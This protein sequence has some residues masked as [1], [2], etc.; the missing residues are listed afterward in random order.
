MVEIP[1]KLPIKDRRVKIAFK[2]F[3]T[4]DFKMAAV[5]AKSG[6]F[7]VFVESDNEKSG[8]RVEKSGVI[9][10]FDERDVEKNDVRDEFRTEYREVNNAN[11][12]TNIG[13]TNS[14]DYLCEFYDHNLSTNDDINNETYTD[15]TTDNTDLIQIAKSLIEVKR[16]LSIVRESTMNEDMRICKCNLTKGEMKE[17]INTTKQDIKNEFKNQFQELENIKSRLNILES[18]KEKLEDENMQLKTQLN[19]LAIVVTKHNAHVIYE[20]WLLLT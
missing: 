19:K 2:Y 13:S 18:Q 8:E 14:C 6:E 11:I 10:V 5:V 17:L 4:A 1:A 3:Y 20:K 16:P 9:N 15:D 12:K 7:D